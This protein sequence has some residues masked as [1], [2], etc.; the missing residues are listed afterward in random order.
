[1]QQLEDRVIAW[2]KSQSDIRAI[3]VIGSRA[4]RDFPADEWSDLDLMIF[5]TDFEKYLASDSWLDDIGEAWLNL[6]LETGRGH[7]ERIVREA[8]RRMLPKNALGRHMLKKLKVYASDTHPHTA[9]QPVP[10]E[11]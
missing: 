5:A 4:R 2:A 3:L 7:P 8:V 6:S 11:F 9:Q 10:W 1:M